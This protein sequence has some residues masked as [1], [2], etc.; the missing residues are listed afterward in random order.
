MRNQRLFPFSADSLRGLPSRVVRGAALLTACLLTA[1]LVPHAAHGQLPPSSATLVT[2]AGADLTGVYDA[3]TSVADVDSQNGADLLVAGNAA[4]TATDGGRTT[5]YLQQSDGSFAQ[6]NAG[7]ADIEREAA[8]AIAD[9]DGQNGPDLLVAGKGSDGP[10]TTLYLQQSDGSFSP[11]NAGLGN[12]RK[13]AVA[14]ADVD[15]QDGPDVLITGEEDFDPTA[16]LYLQQPD[17]SFSEAGAGLDATTGGTVS[18]ADI[19][20]QNGPDL[21]ITGNDDTEVATYFQQSD[22]SFTKNTDAIADDFTNF[23]TAASVA[24]VDGQNGPDVLLVGADTRLLL[25]QSDGSFSAAGAGITRVFEERGSA[26]VEI[27]DVDGQNGPDLLVTGNQQTELNVLS[28][29]FDTGFDPSARLYLQQ[30]DGSFAAADAG[31]TGV[32]A[33]DISAGDIEGDG[34]TD[35]L[36]AGDDLLGSDRT[37]SARL[38][39]NRSSQSSTNRAPQGMRTDVLN[40][41]AAP[42]DSVFAR[43]EF[44]DRDGDQLSQQLT[45][46]PAS[47]AVSFTDGGNGVGEVIFVPAQSQAGRTASFTV[48][49]SDGNGATTSRSF[50]V[51]VSELAAATAILTGVRNAATS[52]ADVDGQ[53]GPDLLVAGTRL[54][55]LFASVDGAEDLSARLYL[56]Q[57]DGTFTPANADLT[58]AA[59]AATAVADVD[60][61]N[62]PDLL[63]A[64]GAPATVGT[65]ASTTLYLQQSDGSFS[66]ADASLND[67]EN[68][69]VSIA[70]VNGQNGPDL[71]ITGQSGFDPTATLYL[72]QSDGSFSPANANLTGVGDFGTRTASSIADVD[73]QNGPDLL[74]AGKTDNDESA[75][76]YLQQSDGSFSPANANL[77]GVEGA[78]AAIA[79]VDGQHGPDLLIG[80]EGGTTLYL[81][82]SDGSF[83]A[84][85]A[86]LPSAANGSASIADVNGDA[87]PDLLITGPESGNDGATSLL[88]Q[89]PGGGFADASAGLTNITLSSSSIVDVTGDGNPDVLAAGTAEDVGSPA[90]RTTAT[91]YENTFGPAVA[92]VTRSVSGAESVDFGGTGASI[93]FSANT[94]GSG[95]VRT[96]KYGMAPSQTPG[97]PSGPNVSKYRFTVETESGL[98]VGAGTELRFDVSTLGGTPNPGA[99]SVY[100][101]NPPGDGFFSTE[102]G[103]SDFTKIADDSVSYDASADELVVVTDDFSELVFTSDSNPLPVELTRFDARVRDESVRLSWQTASE[104]GNTGFQV[105]RRPIANGTDEDKESEWT[106]IG[107][108]DGAGTTSEAQTYRYVDADLPFENDQIEYRLKQIDTDGSTHFSDAITVEQAVT[109]LRLLGTYP[110]PARSQATVRFAVPEQQ[111]VSLKL[112]DVLGRQVRTVQQGE[113]QGRQELQ[114]DVSG[115]PSGTYFLRLTTD[116]QTRTQKLTIT[117]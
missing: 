29:R 10:I 104:T 93:N 15:G 6:A 73:G 44:G 28:G 22:G 54:N 66:A 13:A 108:V 61:Q 107:R 52:I 70:D 57:S 115:L 30:S 17:G 56:Q 90:F 34:D 26:A 38:Y 88:L 113:V 92:A 82:Q 72:Q 106:S 50:Q 4:P 40:A 24:D 47:G 45:G 3:S 102:P 27:A 110:N 71:L 62:G 51:E 23:A 97:I 32:A 33:G 12:V 86:D 111:D 84:A 41:R 48:E 14:I 11:A 101:R 9:I 63:V 5:L 95:A 64:G 81:Q 74:I 79:D 35:L 46:S 39:V 116:G 98:S 69:S 99:I 83:S 19:D 60:G 2:R 67:V 68:G 89:Q 7:L 55:Q 21:L 105:Q 96:V 103:S 91:L 109:E 87:A 59:N 76:L 31:L 114:V 65:S 94:D 80:G 42:G 36:V 8:T 75:T 1:A 117:R 20:G 37:P 18:I 100:R 112:Y 78:A 25:Q 58:G 16:R 53:N 49:A 77:T 43:V 85:G